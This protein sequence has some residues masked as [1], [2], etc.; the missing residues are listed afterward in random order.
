MATP[1]RSAVP[2]TPVT[3]PTPQPV[4]ALAPAAPAAASRRVETEY[5]DINDIEAYEYNPR[6]N[7]KAVKN[8]AA[9]IKAFGFLVPCVIDNN[10][11]LVAGHTRVE[12]AKLL[13]ITEVPCI[14][15]GYL[16]PEEA[17]AFRLIDNK[18]SEQA[19]WNFELLAGEIGK[20]DALGLDFTEFGWTTEE[21]DCLSD[22]IAADCL[23]PAGLVPANAEGQPEATTRRSPLTARV[24]IGELVFFIPATQYR[25]WAD[26]IRTL[27]DFNE[28][29][30]TA[31]LK[32]RLGMLE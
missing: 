29:A 20:L 5:I 28:E 6:N 30:I 24:V 31:E 27:C 26:G 11:V 3:A 25:T 22:L 17:N 23:S 21:I 9:S 8:V 15:A 18:V 2:T 19:E 10:N 12:A 1:K 16:T 32:R 4:L 14:R 13:G 7:A